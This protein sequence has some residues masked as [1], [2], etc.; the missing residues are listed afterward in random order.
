MEGA[1][2]EGS[3]GHE[4]LHKIDSPDSTGSDQGFEKL[5]S[6]S[7]VAPTDDTA[8]FMHVKDES[9]F[10]QKAVDDDDDDEQ[11]ME[12]AAYEADVS[13]KY[14]SGYPPVE[15]EAEREYTGQAGF[16][17]L[18]DFEYERENQK[19]Q[20][21]EEEAPGREEPLLD[22]GEPQTTEENKL[23]LQTS[24]SDIVTELQDV[25][26][27]T[28]KSDTDSAP[29]H[30][31]ENPTSES[32]EQE[33]TLEPEDAFALKEEFVPEEE[34]SIPKLHDP[35]IPSEP[36]EL[37]APDP[38]RCTYPLDTDTAATDTAQSAGEQELAGEHFTNM[39]VA[40]ESAPPITQ[41][42][43]PNMSDETMH[44]IPNLD[45]PE[46]S[47]VELAREEF[48]QLLGEREREALELE[49]FME[50]GMGMELSPDSGSSFEVVDLLEENVSEVS[51]GSASR[52]DKQDVGSEN[53]GTVHVGGMLSESQEMENG[54]EFAKE[55][56]PQTV[57][58]GLGISERVTESSHEEVSLPGLVQVAFHEEGLLESGKQFQNVQDDALFAEHEGV[59]H[60]AFDGEGERVAA[61]EQ[62]SPAACLSSS[63][64]PVYQPS[65]QT[66][67][68]SSFVPEPPVDPVNEVSESTPTPYEFSPRSAEM[69]DA[70][71]AEEPDTAEEAVE[72]AKEEE[73][74]EPT[75][76][77][78]LNFIFLK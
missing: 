21:F 45:E 34:E 37:V 32:Q 9:P 43:E 7:P 6:A 40:L 59:M 8:P 14:P 3:F 54:I 33:M 42:L 70:P 30:V 49:H 18:D 10:L 78:M 58:E 27:D 60:E 12:K 61:A 26:N 68:D 53:Y 67:P 62:A 24:P 50:K 16:V 57:W 52:D 74:L 22:I 2:R 11:E 69:Q 35:E 47:P 39:Q 48:L 19:R 31:Q 72:P 15:F 1:E 28:M 17:D 75:S 46:K 76:K 13:E 65:T 71:M 56:L 5:D 63:P 41:N 77:G 51:P 36:L 23:Y 25:I 29:S 73:A 55:S 4:Q 66:T 20:Q 38:W 64:T 44:G